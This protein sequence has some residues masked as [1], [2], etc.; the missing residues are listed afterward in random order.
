MELN[1]QHRSSRPL[2]IC[3]IAPTGF[4]TEASLTIIVALRLVQLL[5]IKGQ[6]GGQDLSALFN[7]SGELR[8]YSLK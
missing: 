3:A 8:S 5:L 2:L 4:V 6:V 1:K 7:G